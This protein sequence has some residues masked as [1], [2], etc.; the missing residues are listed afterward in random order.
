MNVPAWPE[1]SG[2]ESTKSMYFSTIWCKGCCILQKLL[3]FN[4]SHSNF[5][6]ALQQ[7]FCLQ[8]CPDA[9]S[10]SEMHRAALK[11]A[12]VEHAKHST[13]ATEGNLKKRKF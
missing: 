13:G 2:V 8:L 1:H 10:Q 5:H 7:P 9:I 12:A 11:Q 6:C 3:P 4:A